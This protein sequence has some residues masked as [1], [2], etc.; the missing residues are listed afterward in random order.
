MSRLTFFNA[1]DLRIR[2]C[3]GMGSQN[4][5]PVKHD[6]A[7]RMCDKKRTEII[8]GAR[9]QADARP[10]A[11]ARRAGVA[12]AGKPCRD[13]A[14]QT[15]RRGRQNVLNTVWRRVAPGENKISCYGQWRQGTRREAVRAN[16]DGE[17]CWHRPH[18]A[19]GAVASL[20]SGVAN[21]P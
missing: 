16:R 4:C 7:H 9:G 1:G 18:R 15:L 17:T 8:G 11:R 12:V 20:S 13:D 2:L 19:H 3:V 5:M 14:V 10:F 21:E 6:G